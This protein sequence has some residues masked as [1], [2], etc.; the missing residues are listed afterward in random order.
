MM[1]ESTFFLVFER[2]ELRVSRLVLAGLEFLIEF[3]STRFDVVPKSFGASW[4]RG[5][6]KSLLRE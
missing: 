1:A 4:K 3:F 6:S 5:F 2:Q